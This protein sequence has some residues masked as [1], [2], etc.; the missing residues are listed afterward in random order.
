MIRDEVLEHVQA[1]EP[2]M[3]ECLQQL[4]DKHPSVKQARNVGLFGVI[5]IQ[6]NA[7]GDFLGRVTDPLSPQMAA[8]KKVQPLGRRVPSALPISPVDTHHPCAG[9]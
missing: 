3:T 6:K 8:F 9:V 2:V 5:D 7:R 4:L 1:L